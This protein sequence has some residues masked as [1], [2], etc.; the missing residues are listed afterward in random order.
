MTIFFFHKTSLRNSP[1]RQRTNIKVLKL[2]MA[3]EIDRI[4]IER[5]KQAQLCQK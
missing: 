4:K 3:A 5:N 2:K 1:I